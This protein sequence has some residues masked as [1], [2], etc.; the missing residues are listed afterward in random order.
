MRFKEFVFERALA[1]KDLLGRA[2]ADEHEIKRKQPRLDTFIKKIVSGQPFSTVDGKQVKVKNDPNIINAIKS[3]QIPDVLPIEPEGDVRFTK[4]VKTPEF[5]SEDPEF[6]L[7]KEKEALN[8]LDQQIKTLLNGKTFI[9]LVVGNMLV[10]A[11]GAVNT[12][13]TPKSDFEI[14]DD[15]GNPVAWI[16]HK[17]GSPADP[18]K[19]GQWSGITKFAS[20]PEVISFAEGVAKNPPGKKQ[21]ALSRAIKDVDLQ[22]KAVYGFNFGNDRFG[23]DNVTTVL[24]GPVKIIKNGRQYKL[25]AL[26]EFK[27]GEDFPQEYTPVFTAR[28]SSDRD[29][30]GIHNTRIVIYPFAGRKIV[31]I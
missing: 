13:G 16:S 25:E 17:D 27:N 8:S 30:L 3:R 15:K 11:A 7:S 23:R 1:K 4:L 21:T 20:H 9:P 6:R 24:Q 31:G 5:G 28:Y 2:G 22:K 14:I 12:P 19:F 29:D 10:K 18:K 26:K